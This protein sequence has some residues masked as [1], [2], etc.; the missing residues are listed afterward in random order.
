[1][2]LLGLTGS[3]GMGKST[4]SAMFCAAGVPVYDADAAVHRLYAGPAVKPVG[5]L[6][7]DSIVDG[8]V[9]RAALSRMILADPATLPRLEAVVHPLVA[10][11]RRDFLADC[12]MRA[13]SGCVLDV[14]LLFET[15]G[16]KSVDIVV[17]VSASPEI[18][19]QRVLARPDMTTEK[20]AAISAKQLPDADKR[21]RSHIVIDTGRGFDPA[22]RQVAALLVSLGL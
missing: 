6:F 13:V 10:A 3:I 15:G 19:K 9:D 5:A 7:P 22:R 17:T 11:S 12:R 1:M 16:D 2:I 18:Q 20:F 21:R 4:T 8:R 14:P